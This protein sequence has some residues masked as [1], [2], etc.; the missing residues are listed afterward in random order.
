[1]S[2]SNSKPS[3]IVEFDALRAIAA[4]NLM[5]FHFTHVYSVKY[6]YDQPLG[7]QFPWG[8]YGV[9]LFFM[10][11]G[12]VNAMTILRSRDPGKF[13]ISRALRIMPCYYIVLGINLL[14]FQLMP[15]ASHDRWSWP[16]LAA[17]LTILPNLFGFECFEPVMWT[18][19][20]E[21]LFYGI[22]ILMFTRGWLERP[23]VAVIGGLTLS[24]LG[25]FGINAINGILPPESF[26]VAY[27][28]M[29]RQLF[30]LDYFPLFATGI[31][32]HELWITSLLKLENAPPE[33]KKHSTWSKRFPAST[34]SLFSD[35]RQVAN[36]A[37]IMACIVAFHLTDQHG[38]NPVVS[39]LLTMLLILSAFQKLAFLRRP[40]FVFVSG[41]S[42]MLYLMHDNMGTVLIYWLNN[43][44]G[45]PPIL[46]FLAAVVFS[47]VIAT[48]ATYYLE[49]PLT[50]FL[51]NNLVLKYNLGRT[52][53]PANQMALEKNST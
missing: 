8:K 11:S 52:R 35:S 38:H 16:Q 22:L 4:L 15:L 47:L 43:N 20:V 21:V 49:R 40:A 31:M 50:R 5:L 51:R 36:I 46:C 30:L 17:N 10:L 23:I 45:V 26:A 44:L 39:L 18:L 24:V 33:V 53:L 34:I 6:G 7:F 28:K 27:W 32:I 42:Y 48:A 3:R 9:Q 37:A 12:L 14:L 1:M 41:I 25:C 2:V 13:L 19:Q 29:V